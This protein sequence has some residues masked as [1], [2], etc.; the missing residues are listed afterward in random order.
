M[1]ITNKLNFKKKPDTIVCSSVI[2][3]C[4]YWEVEG[5]DR[6]ITNAIWYIP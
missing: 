5:R 1:I 6:R 4:S 3:V 2:L